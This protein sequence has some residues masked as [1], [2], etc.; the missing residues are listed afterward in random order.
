MIKKQF[1]GSNRIDLNGE[2]LSS[3][4]TPIKGGACG[5]AFPKLKANNVTI[6]CYVSGRYA[7]SS[8]TINGVLKTNNDATIT[9]QSVSLRFNR[10]NAD[11]PNT[12]TINDGRIMNGVI[13]SKKEYEAD[14]ERL[15]ITFNDVEMVE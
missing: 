13:I 5:L 9:E 4:G 8:G 7:S 14:A 3:L 15:T 2:T 11:T 1:T 10:N 12:F 6:I